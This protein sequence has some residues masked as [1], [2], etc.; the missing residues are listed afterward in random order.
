MSPTTR[1]APSGAATA[2]RPLDSYATKV[3]GDAFAVAI[4]SPGAVLS[5]GCFDPSNT[6]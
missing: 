4:M 3:L 2:R 1:R 6:R 5:T